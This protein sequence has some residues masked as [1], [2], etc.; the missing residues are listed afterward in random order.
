MG[1]C[2]LTDNTCPRCEFAHPSLYQSQLGMSHPIRTRVPFLFR[3]CRSLSPTEL[4]ASNQIPR[5]LTLPPPPPHQ[6]EKE[7][8][9]A[10]RGAELFVG[11]GARLLST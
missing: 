6:P 5:L 1:N 3:A 8:E 10:Y 9:S 7:K 11:R 4:S 2:S